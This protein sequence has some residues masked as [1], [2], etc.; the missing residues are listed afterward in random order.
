MGRSTRRRPS[1][2]PW[3]LVSIGL[4]VETAREVGARMRWQRLP[5]GAVI[6]ARGARA[7]GWCHVERGQVTSAIPL[8]EGWPAEQ[9]GAAAASRVDQ[10]YGPGAWFGEEALEP[11]KKASGMPKLQPVPA[12]ATT[13]AE[14]PRSKKKS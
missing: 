4:T 13:L 5:R 11:A 12:S 9:P 1:I 8:R 7:D 14:T 10:L 3:L 6:G 2:D